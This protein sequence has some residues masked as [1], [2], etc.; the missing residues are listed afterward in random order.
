MSYE[1]IKFVND[2][3]ELEVN[4]SPQEDTVWLSLNEM[5]LLFGRD[6]SVISRHIRNIFKE[7][8]LS[9][10]QTVAKNAI[11]KTEGAKNVK[12]YIDYYNLDVIISV[13]Y[14]VKSHNG[15][16]FRKWANNVL[17]EYLIKGYVINENRTLIT[18]ENY[19]NLINRV[20]SI[21][22]RLDR[23]ES[24][25][26]LKDKIIYD[27][28][29]FDAFVLLNQLCEL[30]HLSIVLI[31]PYIDIKT[32]DA[33]KAKLPDVSLTII[34]S[35]KNNKLSQN[36]IKAFIKQYGILIVKIDDSY[37]DRY[38]VIDN[39]LFYHVGSSINYLGKRFS[40]ITVIEDDDIIETLRKRIDE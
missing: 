38:I 17:K 9:K 1:I 26:L 12:R 13:G 23:I 37:H 21:E 24:Y 11:V 19:I 8:E 40:Q 34:T 4:V 15:V 28:R 2:N 32:L 7:N 10:D 30:A 35:T 33:F 18:N 29:V 3:L 22:N 39:T 16:V 14:R 20:D 31:D 5:C 27:G 36:D 25:S 6:K